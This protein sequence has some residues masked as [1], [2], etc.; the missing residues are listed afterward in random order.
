M[1]ISQTQ[2]IGWSAI[3]GGSIAVV[4]FISLLLL[5]V[6][7]EPFGTINDFLAIPSGL[8]LLPLV[9]G[10]YRLN[11]SDYPL[12]SLI[13]LIAGA[14][15]FLATMIGSILLLAN[16]IDFQTSLLP[17]LGGF[18]LVG[19]CVLINSVLALQDG[20]LPKGLAWAGVL[21]AITPTL[22][23]AAVPWMNRIADGLEA[24][25]GQTTGFQISPLLIIVFILGFIS[26]GGLP[27]WFIVIGRLFAQARLLLLGTAAVA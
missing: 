9:Y 19:L 24:M 6:V 18:G 5:F 2:F 27:I 12:T 21:L 10:L 26:Y 16:R 13:A 22:A 23:L 11:A 8:L 20:A 7:G 1:T 3:L 4:G 14:A 17:G 25:A 15:G